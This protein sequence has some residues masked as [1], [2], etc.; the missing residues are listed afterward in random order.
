MI[1][2]AVSKSPNLS[3]FKSSLPKGGVLN[4][5]STRVGINV[6]KIHPLAKQKFGKYTNVLG[7]RA[8]GK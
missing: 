5:P 7:L 1:K 8:A 4:S 2:H 6:S 3:K